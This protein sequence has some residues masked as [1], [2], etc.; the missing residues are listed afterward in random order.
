MRKA[1]RLID[2]DIKTVGQTGSGLDMRH[3]KK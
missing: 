1:A 3:S 2:R